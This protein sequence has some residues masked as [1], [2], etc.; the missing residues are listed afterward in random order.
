MYRESDYFAAFL[1][2]NT[3]AMFLVVVDWQAGKGK[4]KT[5]PPARVISS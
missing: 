4:T 3:N 5:L 2:T 1:A